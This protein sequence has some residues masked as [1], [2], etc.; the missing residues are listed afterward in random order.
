MLPR[1]M[2]TREPRKHT[3]GPLSNKQLA[4]SS[5][6]QRCGDIE[7]A[8]FLADA[9]GPANLVMDMPI[10][11]ERWGSSSNPRLNCNLHYPLPSDIDKR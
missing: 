5:R 10:V 8:A 4:D 6:G 3:T 9:A 2:D 7:L 1:V 11:Q